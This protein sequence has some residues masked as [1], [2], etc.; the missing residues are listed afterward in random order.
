MGTGNPRCSLGGVIRRRTD[1]IFKVDSIVHPFIRRPVVRTYIYTP[2]FGT[3]KIV[4]LQVH[5][6]AADATAR[7]ELS[8]L[9]RTITK[10]IPTNT[11][12]FIIGDL[13]INLKAAA[14]PVNAP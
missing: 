8:T 2:T 12:A 14:F 9:M 3:L 1:K 13:N 4:L 11:P 10:I 5:L 7:R 6:R